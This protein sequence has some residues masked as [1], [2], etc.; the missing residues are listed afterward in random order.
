MKLAIIVIA[1]GAA[2][3]YALYG[4]GPIEDYMPTNA[5]RSGRDR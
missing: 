1:I 4:G 3:Y 5:A 2:I